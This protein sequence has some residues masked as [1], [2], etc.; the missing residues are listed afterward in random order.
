MKKN[1]YSICSVLLFFIILSNPLQSV[2]GAKNGLLLW[3]NT[4]IPTLLPF[5]IISNIMIQLNTTEKISYLLY[6]ITSKL[7]GISKQAN[8]SIIMGML[9]GY[10]MGAKATADLVTYHKITRYEGQYMLNWCNNVSPMFIISFIIHTTLKQPDLLLQILIAL[11]GAPLLTALLLNISF[12]RHNSKII[13]EPCHIP[14][15]DTPAIDFKL[16]DQC[17]MN[18][19]ET[20][21]KLGGYII[22]FS[23]LSNFLI[24]WLHVNAYLKSFILGSVEITTGI[25][26]I[27]TAPLSVSNQFMIICII[28]AFGGLSSIAQTESIIKSSGL[29]IGKYIRSKLLTA[30]LSFVIIVLT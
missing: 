10:P 6:P 11:Y 27:G 2:E 3:F 21:V 8:Y 23:I 12:R 14:K 29:S 19:F 24:Y 26:Y 28:T 18:G 9:C 16:I 7:L 5:I 4:I 15:L 20:I 17:I 25:S 13:M 1:I 30:F 22:L